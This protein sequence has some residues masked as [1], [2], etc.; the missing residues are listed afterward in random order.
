VLNVATRSTALELI[1]GPV[2]SPRELEGSFRDIALINRRFGGTAAVRFALRGLDAGSLLDV[3]S[4]IADIP[5]AILESARRG[6][7][8]LAVTCLDNNETLV[9]LARDRNAGD[10]DMTF[11]CGDGTA[12]P[13]ADGAFDVAMCNLALHHFAPD[14]AIALLRELRRVSRL[15][16][17]VTDLSRSRLTLLAAYAFIAFFTRN[18]LTCNDAPLS[19]R[20]AYTQAEAVE[21]ARRAGWRNPRTQSHRGIR[22]IL[23][24]DAAV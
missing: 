9:A 8:R 18:R 20:R 6:G 4:G 2:E 19:A 13:F 16:P 15:T 5:K 23:R 3:A 10:P 11:V 21:L 7:K 1:D 17:I 22:M 12:L 14:A 24:D